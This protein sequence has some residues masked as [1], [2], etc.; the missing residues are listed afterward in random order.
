MSAVLGQGLLHTQQEGLSHTKIPQVLS[1][2]PAI[3]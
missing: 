3:L 2:V 1:C